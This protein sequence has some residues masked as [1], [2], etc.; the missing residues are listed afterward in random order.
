MEED[1]WIEREIFYVQV[2]VNYEICNGLEDV[3][4]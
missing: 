3:I 1:W 4:L 2:V